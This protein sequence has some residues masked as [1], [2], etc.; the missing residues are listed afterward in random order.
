MELLAVYERASWQRVNRA[1]STV[2]YSVN[3]IQYNKKLISQN[4]QIKEADDSSKYLGLPNILGK[5][6]SIVFGYLK[7]KVKASI[8][9]WSEKNVSKPAKE[10]LLKMVT[11]ALP[12]FAMNVFLLPMELIKDIEKCM[13]KFFWSTS[14]KSKSKISWMA[15]ERMSKHKYEGG[16]GFRCLRDFNVAMLGKQ[17][18]RLLT[19][20]DSLVARVYKARYYTDKYFMDADLGSSPSFVWRSV[21]EAKR[22]ISSGSC[23]RIGNGKEVSVLQQPWLQDTDN[24]YIIT[25]FP[26]IVQQKVASLFCTDAKQWDLEFI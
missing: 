6:K 10:I 5:N 19:N 8:Q 23:W 7:D 13:A 22:V 20:P 25:N 1:K 26:T 3:V 21:L 14:Q 12:S 15:W 2:F 18:W 11:Q 17:C 24:P 4:L 9:N 16:L